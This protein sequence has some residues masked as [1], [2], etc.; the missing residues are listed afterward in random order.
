MP[1]ERYSLGTVERRNPIAGQI[2]L[3]MR[4]M[5]LGLVRRLNIPILP[6]GGI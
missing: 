2:K 4:R 1:V 3:A 6:L 5:M